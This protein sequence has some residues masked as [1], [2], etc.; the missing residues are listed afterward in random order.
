MKIDT[1]TF[2]AASV[3][4]GGS[5][6]KTGNASRSSEAVSLKRRLDRAPGFAASTAGQCREDSGNQA[7]HCTG[8]FRDQSRSHRRRSYSKP[9]AIWSTASARPDVRASRTPAAG[10]G[11]AGPVHHLLHEE[12][13][14]LKEIRPE[15]LDA[16]GQSKLALT[17]QL[18]TVENRRNALTSGPRQ[19][20]RDVPA[21]QQWLS[22][23]PEEAAS[24]A[25]WTESSPWP[26]RPSGY[27]T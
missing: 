25:L 6:A 11:T 22:R 12:A 18:D 1:S 13:T 2:S 16:I 10:K 15:A 17:Q 9:P 23:H 8:T 3:R 7:G 21:M 5:P 14:A 19:R 20:H 26:P 4:T 27:T 24:N